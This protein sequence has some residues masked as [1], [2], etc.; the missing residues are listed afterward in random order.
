MYK[1]HY[2]MITLKYEHYWGEHYS[3]QQNNV[4]DKT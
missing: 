1:H 2:E 4:N 3:L